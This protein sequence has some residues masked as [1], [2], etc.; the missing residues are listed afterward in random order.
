LCLFVFGGWS[1]D[2]IPILMLHFRL[3]GGTESFEFE[4]IALL[5]VLGVVSKG[6]DVVFLFFFV[7][8]L[9]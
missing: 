6:F 1:F 3:V 8:G 2:D 4:L 9:Y 7:K 5:K